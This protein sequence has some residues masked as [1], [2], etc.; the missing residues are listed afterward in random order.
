MLYIVSTP[1]GSLEDITFR[2]IAMLKSCDYILAEDTR[3]TITLLRHYAIEKKLVSYNDIND[4]RKTPSII[5]DLK[6]G[7]TVC[8][9]SDSGTPCINDPGYVLVKECIANSI[10]V[11]PVPGP[12]AFLSA[13]VCSGLPT[14]RFTYYGFLPKGS[15]RRERILLQIIDRN[16]TSILYESPHRLIRTI[17]EISQRCNRELVVA[18]ELTKHFE[19]FIYGKPKDI[20]AKLEK[21]SIKG[22]FVI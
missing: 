10:K 8:L 16:E 17:E 9:V 2:A 1:I 7:K 14:D 5:A 15:G 20:L 3:R 18:R 6:E 13:L 22:E 19:E 12:S 4:S 11:S 21:R